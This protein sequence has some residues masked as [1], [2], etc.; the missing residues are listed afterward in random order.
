M[1]PLEP[2]RMT[3]EQRRAMD[4]ALRRSVLIVPDPLLVRIE[5][6]ID[7]ILRGDHVGWDQA[8]S[9]LRDEIRKELAQ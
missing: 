3:P 4:A 8:L 2:Y 6:K 9:A 5:A 1:T 7:A